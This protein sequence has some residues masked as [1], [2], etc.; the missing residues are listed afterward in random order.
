[1]YGTDPYYDLTPIKAPAA[2]GGVKFRI[3]SDWYMK[4]V[5]LTAVFTASGVVASRGIA[6]QYQDGDGN[7][8]G[9]FDQLTIVTAGLAGRFTW[10]IN[11]DTATIDPAKGP[12]VR[13]VPDILMPSGHQLALTASNEDAGDQFS[14]LFLWAQKFPTGPM[15][16]ARGATPYERGVAPVNT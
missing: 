16:P 9:Q 7:V 13:S 6:L 5:M 11:V 14:A 8:Y 10:A 1:M 12:G 2:G 3:P 15:E 4:P